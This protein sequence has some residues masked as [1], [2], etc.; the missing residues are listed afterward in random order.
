M[1]TRALAELTDAELIVISATDPEA[2]CTLYDRRAQPLLAFIY[3]RV[4][5]PEV[6]ADLL[7]ETFARAFENRAKFRDTGDSGSAWL[8][9]IASRLISRYYR[10]KTVELKAV[11]RLGIR[12]PQ[13]D[14]ESL[15]AFERIAESEAGGGVLVS[16]AINQI[17]PGER[18]AVHL[19]IVE[20]LDYREIASRLN[21]SVVAARVRVHRGL[22]RLTKLMEATS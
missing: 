11:E 14:D 15:A 9:T 20:D 18:E 10:R 5:N 1:A 19:R 4:G 12:V 6:A 22:A 17:P 8:Y 2:F 7:A 13:L 21:C 3:R 16:D